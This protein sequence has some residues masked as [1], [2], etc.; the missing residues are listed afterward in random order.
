M[1]G[2]PAADRYVVVLVDGLGWHLLRDAAVTAPYL[3][4][5]LG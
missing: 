1:L 5:L 4:S 3:A 2:L